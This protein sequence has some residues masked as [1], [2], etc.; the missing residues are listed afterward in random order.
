MY[1]FFRSNR[2]YGKKR[3]GSCVMVVSELLTNIG[4][5][6]KQSMHSGFYAS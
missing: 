5:C 2:N 3:S 4:L 1:S 6:L